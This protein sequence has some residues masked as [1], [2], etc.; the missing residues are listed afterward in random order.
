MTRILWGH[1]IVYIFTEATG[2]LNLHYDIELKRPL[3][4]TKAGGGC[5]ALRL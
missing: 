4:K 2:R 5:F 1:R 3:D